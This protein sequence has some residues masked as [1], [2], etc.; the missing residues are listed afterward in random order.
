MRIAK[1]EIKDQAIIETLLAEAPVGRLGTM[2][3]DGY[4]MIKPV[5]FV[6]HRG[7]IYF[8]SAPEG[9]K[10]DHILRDSRVCFEVDWPIG[11]VKSTGIPC[12]ADY[13]FRSVIIRGRAHLVAEREEK[14]AALKAL[15]EKY[16]PEGGYGSFPED[17][18]AATSVV[19]IDIAMLTAKQ[20]L[21]KEHEQPEV[22]RALKDRPVPAAVLERS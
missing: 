21:G 22:L 7:R 4:P 8:H 11:Y 18:L 10:I 9:E 6:H 16:Q 17:K 15:M 2:G 13:L 5:N 3:Q 20:D 19:C 1:K 14:V 12:R